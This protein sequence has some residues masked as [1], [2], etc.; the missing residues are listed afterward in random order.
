MGSG[1]G[2]RLRQKASAVQGR[3]LDK[4]F[5]TPRSTKPRSALPRPVD[6]AIE[7]ARD[8]KAADIVVLDLVGLCSFTD[9]FLICTGGSRR[10]TQAVADSIT[11]RLK[12]AGI[13]PSHVEGQAE[14]NWILIDYG[15]FV[16]HIFTPDTREFYDLERLWR[17]GKKL[18]V[19]E[20][21]GR[22][23]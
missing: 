17:E 4:E 20:P 16:V 14:G 19:A 7:A 5:I 22:E 8:K 6:I 10:Q 9:R 11:Q 12:D 3:P 13:R 18:D 2:C 23:S 21:A 1:G 15:D